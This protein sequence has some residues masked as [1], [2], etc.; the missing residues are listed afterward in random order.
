MWSEIVE[1]TGEVGLV[2]TAVQTQGIQQVQGRRRV[3]RA[4]RVYTCLHG[5]F[6][7]FFIY[8]CEKKVM[9]TKQNWL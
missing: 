2:Q 1:P 4:T 6:F 8:P 7:I 3:D 9:K 5:Y